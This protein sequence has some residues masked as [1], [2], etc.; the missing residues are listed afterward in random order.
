MF[1]VCGNMSS[2]VD[3]RHLQGL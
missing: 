2:L 1:Y 3:R